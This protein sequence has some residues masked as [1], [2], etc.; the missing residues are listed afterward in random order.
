MD[1]IFIALGGALGALARVSLVRLL[2]SF[3][4]GLPCPVLLANLIGCFFMGLAWQF[5]QDKFTHLINLQS[6]L[7]LGFLGAFTTFS[8]FS[9]DF[10]NLWQK[11]QILEGFIYA[12]ASFFLSIA[13]FATGVALV[14]L[15]T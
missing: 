2:P 4:L 1:L 15:F 5:F 6:F 14:K 12:S 13:L 3:V 9:A 10:F 7:T 11:N 8:S